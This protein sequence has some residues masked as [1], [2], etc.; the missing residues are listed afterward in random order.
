MYNLLVTEVSGAWDR[1]EYVLP[2]GRYLEHTEDV[3]KAHFSS[4]TPKVVAE[5]QTLPTVFAYETPVGSPARVG[6]ITSILTRDGEVRVTFGLDELIAP[7]PQ[8]RLVSLSWEL[9]IGDYELNRTH[10]AIKGV[11]LINVIQRRRDPIASPR[12]YGL[13]GSG[14]PSPAPPLTT[15]T[16]GKAKVFVVH[17]RDAASKSEVARFLDKLG[18]EPVILHE[19]PNAGR[20]LIT[21]F[22]EE[23]ADIAF[24]VVLMTPDDQGALAGC[25]MAPRARQNVIFEL[26]FFIGRLGASRVCA[27]V[28]GEL[29]KPSDFDAV[30]YIQYSPQSSWKAEL[31]RELRHAGLPVDANLVV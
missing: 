26:G 1:R 8:E 16:T 6:W 13:L 27:L 2:L 22:Q 12:P 25:Q 30:V 29:E 7:I 9:Q 15:S 3:T 20:T 19:R 28:S 14:V 23:S 10:W 31:I 5:L 17:G 21:K 24:A 11:D 4:L 18:L